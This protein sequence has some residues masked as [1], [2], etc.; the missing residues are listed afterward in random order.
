MGAGHRFLPQAWTRQAFCWGSVPVSA[1]DEAAGLRRFPFAEPHCCPL[2]LKYLKPS[3]TLSGQ[4]EKGMM[5]LSAVA[6]PGTKRGS[7]GSWPR[8]PV[9]GL[10]ASGSNHGRGAARGAKSRAPLSAAGFDRSVT[11]PGVQQK[12]DHMRALQEIKAFQKEHPFLSV[13]HRLL[14]QEKRV[15]FLSPLVAFKEVFPSSE[16]R[17]LCEGL[18]HPE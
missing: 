16:Q 5:G 17:Y 12:P 8:V 11:P 1:F 7:P 14:Q 15:H 18:S 6:V 13:T 10:G 4:D 2:D 9:A 3:V